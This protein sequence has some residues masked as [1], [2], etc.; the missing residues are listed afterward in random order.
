MKMTTPFILLLS[1]LILPFLKFHFAFINSQLIGDGIDNI[2]V[3]T[4]FERNII[5]FSNILTG[6]DITTIYSSNG[7]YPY[8]ET[9]LFTEP[10]YFP[11][12]LYS[13][14]KTLTGSKLLAFNSL[15]IA[16]YAINLFSFYYLSRCLKNTRTSSILASIIFS[17]G[18]FFSI[19]YV[20][21]QNQ[22]AF[23]FPL[24]FAFTLR[25][26]ETNKKDFLFLIYI[27]LTLQFFSCNYF[28]LYG[29]YFSFLAFYITNLL[30]IKNITDFRK[31]V[32]SKTEIML[33]LNLLIPALL[34]VV[35]IFIFYGWFLIQNY[36]LYPKRILLENQHYSNTILSFLRIPDVISNFPSIVLNGETHNSAHIGFLPLVVIIIFLMYRKFR[37]TSAWILLGLSLLFFL[38][39]LGPIISIHNF[40]IP[41]PYTIL[42]HIFP[43][44]KNLRVPSRIFIISWF[45]ISVFLLMLTRTAIWKNSLKLKIATFSLIFV[46]FFFLTSINEANKLPEQITTLKL[47]LPSNSNIVFIKKKKGIYTLNDDGFPEWYLLNTEYK[48]P[49]GYSGLTLPFQYYLINLLYN[50]FLTDELAQYFK[51]LGIS[52]IAIS[53]PESSK[54][55]KLF[56]FDFKVPKSLKFLIYDRANHLYLFKIENRNERTVEFVNNNITNIESLDYIV[57]ETSVPKKQEFLNDKKQKTYWQS[58]SSGFQTNLDFIKIKLPYSSKKSYLIKLNSGPFL[59]RLPYGLDISCGSTIQNYSFPKIDVENFLSKPIS[60]Q[61]MYFKINNCNSNH[62]E[63]R[64]NKTTPYSVFMLS[65]LEIFQYK[66][67]P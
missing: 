38:F 27:T 25:Y 19:Q 54:N 13:L 66:V 29:L 17:S 33:G 16:A 42:Y 65:E 4:I 30:R 62:L 31:T 41:G 26:R 47:D 21:L 24:I 2:L 57:E 50:N 59:E 15:F 28:G 32:F 46:E 56:E 48:T 40:E 11:T 10:L 18:H 35:T 67:E 23:S 45:F 7:L 58:F 52:H 63:I 43:G 9:N 36:E 8:T 34:F 53:H 22:F 55:D 60:N 12:L 6:Q 5:N 3:L 51:E 14:L 49:N 37:S 44:F 64:I 20:H 1:C 61:F 39:S